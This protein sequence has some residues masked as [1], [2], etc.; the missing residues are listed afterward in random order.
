MKNNFVYLIF[1]SLILFFVSCEEKD[2]KNNQDG[3]SINEGTLTVY[4]DNSI[5]PILDSAIKMYQQAYPL[6]HLTVDKGNARKCVA[7]LLSGKTEAVVMARPYLK[8]EDSLMKVYD[9]KRPQM[10]AARD[11]LVFYTSAAFPIDTLNDIQIRDILLGKS[12]FKDLYPTLQFDPIIVCNEQNSSEYANLQHLVAKDSTIK[13]KI[14]L[15]NGSDSVKQFIKN[16]KQAIGIGYLSNIVNQISYKALKISFN[17]STGR[18]EPPQIVHQA[19]IVQGRYPYI[20]EYRIILKED[21]M[22]RPFW[23]SSFLAKETKVQKY[24]LESGIVPEYARIKL[25]PQDNV[26]R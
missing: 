13:F 3:L 10:I 16:N 17:D 2:L 24:F 14:L 7:M 4:I 18:R 19:F 25:I 20:I 12:T 5:Y 1:F 22:S 15:L 6:I 26:I 8:D 11:A 9:V 21:R 23:F